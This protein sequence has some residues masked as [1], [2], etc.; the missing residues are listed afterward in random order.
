VAKDVVICFIEGIPN[1]IEAPAPKK[2]PMASGFFQPGTDNITNTN[3]V[4]VIFIKSN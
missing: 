4:Q 2:N 1:L 3:P